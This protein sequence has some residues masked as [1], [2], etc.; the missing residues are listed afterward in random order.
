MPPLMLAAEPAATVPGGTLESQS[1]PLAS[2]EAVG[3]AATG[4]GGKTSILPLAF[5]ADGTNGHC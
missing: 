5:K 2:I 3:H 1:T 4:I